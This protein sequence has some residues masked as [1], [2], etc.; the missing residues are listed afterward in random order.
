MSEWSEINAAWDIGGCASEKLL[1][2]GETREWGELVQYAAQN[3]HATSEEAWDG[4]AA[5]IRGYLESLDNLVT[6]DPYRAQ[7]APRNKES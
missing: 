6:V 4:M 3:T 2:L 7:F 1:G 5:A